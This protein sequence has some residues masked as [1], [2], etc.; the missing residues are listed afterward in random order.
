MQ[1]RK[2]AKRRTLHFLQAS[3]ATM[4]LKEAGQK[5]AKILKT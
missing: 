2:P 1:K 5:K 4:F 3:G